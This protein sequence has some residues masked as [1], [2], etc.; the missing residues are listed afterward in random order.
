MALPFYTPYR[1]S[2]GRFFA[3]DQSLVGYWQLQGNSWD[4]SGNGANGTD[5]S[6]VYNQP[7]FRD[8]IGSAYYSGSAYSSMGD[9]LAFEYT[10]PW[11][12][13]CWMKNLSTVSSNIFSKQ[14]NAGSYIGYGFGTAADG[15]LQAFIYG[16]GG[17]GSLIANYPS[18][19]NDRLHF[20][21]WTYDGSN[22][23]AGYRFYVDG[24]PVTAT[25]VTNIAN[26]GSI[27]TTTPLQI[28][29][30][31]GANSL[32]NGYIEEASVFS[33]ILSSQEISQYYQWAT[34]Q[35]KPK[36]LGYLPP[37]VSQAYGFFASF[38]S[39]D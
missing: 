28:S 26:S 23:N 20:V 25:S 11:T 8:G 33:R 27:I 21:V 10:S 13:A 35:S 37:V 24:L 5:T 39:S 12:M 31:A 9:V 22:S 2:I 18:K 32:W 30:R 36:W 3:G 38:L 4:N 34:S 1:G 6:V 29:G 16:G 17:T 19:Y 7:G 14:Q 15:T